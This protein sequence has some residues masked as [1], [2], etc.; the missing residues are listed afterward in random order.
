[1]QPLFNYL[2]KELNI[3][4]ITYQILNFVFVNPTDIYNKTKNKRKIKQ[5]CLNKLHLF[6]NKTIITIQYNTL[7]K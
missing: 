4:Q 5:F 2:P 6:I 1:M 7:L 3:L